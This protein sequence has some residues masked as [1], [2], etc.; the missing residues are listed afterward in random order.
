M[1]YVQEPLVATDVNGSDIFLVNMHS[2]DAWRTSAGLD[3]KKNAT[4]E[5]HE[6]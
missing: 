6:K 4:I 1:A 3:H 2:A 5:H